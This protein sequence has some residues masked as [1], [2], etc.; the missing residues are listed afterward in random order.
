MRPPA[1]ALAIA[2]TQAAKWK[3]THWERPDYDALLNKAAVTTDADERLDLYQQAQKL[4]TEEGGVIIPMFVHQ[5]LAVR[6]GCGGYDPHPQNFNLDF[7]T[8]ECN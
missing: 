3:E 1:S 6:K 2:Y 5:V 4:M 7:S 8:I